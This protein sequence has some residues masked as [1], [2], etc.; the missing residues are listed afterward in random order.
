[1]ASDATIKKAPEVFV[2][3]WRQLLDGIVVP[4]EDR[5]TLV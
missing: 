5:N 2:R 3:K 4:I 1:V